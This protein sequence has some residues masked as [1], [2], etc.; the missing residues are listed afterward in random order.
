M[1]DSLGEQHI[2][3][4][5]SPTALVSQ[6]AVQLFR[7]YTGKGPPQARVSMRDELVLIVLRGTLTKAELELA[8][9]GCGEEVL[10][11]RDAAQGAM[12]DQLVALVERHFGRRVEAFFSHNSI[13]PDLA[14]ELFVLDGSKHP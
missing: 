12:R 9:S 1:V 14:I 8:A 11:L 4:P 13:D 5:Q 7:K 2:G 6:G 3:G 10:R